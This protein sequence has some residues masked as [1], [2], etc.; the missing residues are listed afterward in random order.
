[1]YGKMNFFKVAA[2]AV[3]LL[4]VTSLTA[5]AAD[6]AAS[7]GQEENGY[8]GNK[9][10]A[11]CHPDKAASF[12]TNIHMQA[13]KFFTEF[14]GC[15]TCHGPGANHAKE[16]DPTMIRNPEKLDAPATNEICLGCHLRGKLALWKGSTHETRSL[17][18]TNCHSI[19]N[20]FRH[21]LVMDNEIDVCA[22]CH[23]DVRAELWRSSHHPIREG[24]L[25]CTNCHN[26]HG[27]IGPK[28][29]DA[30]T[31]NDKCFECHAEK[32]GPYLFEHKPV[33]EDC[34]NCHTPHGSNHNKLLA[35]KSIYLCQ[36]C[37]SGSR[38]PG[39]LY[40]MGAVTNIPGNP[41]RSLGEQAIYRDCLNC[42]V[43][44]HGSNSPSGEF[45]LR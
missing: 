36:S 3:F 44:I 21:L 43:N 31:I 39:T 11:G 41:S 23:G 42:H 26:P 29:V 17:A 13:G 33:V 27:T 34:M 2:A 35:R 24:K 4:A 14:Q 8:V 20:G 15:E 30:L 37:H 1:M 38:H 28:L 7:G 18:C 45:F 25:T 19:H 9:V 12:Q 16:G 6:G 40:A 10:C 22:R 32:R 5:Y